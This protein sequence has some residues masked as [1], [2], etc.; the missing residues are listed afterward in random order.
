ML[1]IKYRFILKAETKG[2]TCDAF[3]HFRHPL[4]QHVTSQ[5]IIEFFHATGSVKQILSRH[6]SCMEVFSTDLPFLLVDQ[7]ELHFL[8]MSEQPG[9]YHVVQ[10]NVELCSFP[11]ITIIVGLSIVT[12]VNVYKITILLQL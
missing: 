12:D 3:V 1:T 4:F 7:P 10:P 5:L 6:G 2:L 11:E 8:T 9:V